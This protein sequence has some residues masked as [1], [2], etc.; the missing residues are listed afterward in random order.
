MKRRKSIKTEDFLIEHPPEQC[1]R[2][3]SSSVLKILDD[4]ARKQAGDRTQ[5]NRETCGR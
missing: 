3:V 2:L 4:L 1:R 5:H